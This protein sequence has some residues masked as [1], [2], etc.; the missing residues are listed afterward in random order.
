MMRGVEPGGVEPL[1]ES[2]TGNAGTD[3]NEPHFE[4][5]PSA[6]FIFLLPLAPISKDEKRA[7]IVQNFSELF[8]FQI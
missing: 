8:C 6:A 5:R 4:S 2:L 1:H 7:Q 3:L